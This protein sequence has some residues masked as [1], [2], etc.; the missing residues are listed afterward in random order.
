[1]GPCDWYLP[2]VT[3]S[4][5]LVL[6]CCGTCLQRETFSGCAG[7]IV[8][9][10]VVGGAQVWGALQPHPSGALPPWALRL[11]VLRLGRWPQPQGTRASHPL[12]LD[13]A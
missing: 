5:V 7:G 9:D 13:P 12:T 3:V 6:V 1:M 2:Y 8:L 4:T 10:H 11:L